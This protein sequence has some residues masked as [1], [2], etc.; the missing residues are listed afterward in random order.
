MATWRRGLWSTSWVH[1]LN[2]APFS[3]LERR[4]DALGDCMEGAAPLQ[5][6][7]PSV[8]CWPKGGTATP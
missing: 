2:R 8:G 1:L 4:G 7:V 5:S 6:A 3:V